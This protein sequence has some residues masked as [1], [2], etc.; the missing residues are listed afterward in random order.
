MVNF[1]WHDSARNGA[2]DGALM[3][4]WMVHVDCA[5][6]GALDGASDGVA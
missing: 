1:I 5:N 3:V 4:D 6:D 2:F